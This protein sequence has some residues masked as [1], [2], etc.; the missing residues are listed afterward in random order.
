[1]NCYKPT[2]R[3]RDVLDHLAAN[4]RAAGFAEL[5]AVTGGYKRPARAGKALTALLR[6]MRADGLIRNVSFG[7]HNRRRGDIVTDAGREAL[8]RLNA[9]ET[10]C[11][12]EGGPNVRR[13]TAAA[14][15]K[16]A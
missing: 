4:P 6:A 9:G 15:G 14:P 7:A 5:L 12:G 11:S 13:F 8:D 16:A 10:V 1:M 2:S 3:A